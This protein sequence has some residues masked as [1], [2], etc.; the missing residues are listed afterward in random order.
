MRQADI[1]NQWYTKGIT[2]QQT[3]WH[4]QKQFYFLIKRVLTLL[5]FHFTRSKLRK[6]PLFCWKFDRKFWTVKSKAMFTYKRPITIGKSQKTTRTLV[7]VRQRNKR[8]CARL[9]KH[10]ALICGC[11]WKHHESMAP[12]VSQ[13]M[14]KTKTF[15]LD[16]NL[17]CANYVS[18]VATCVICHQL[19]VGQIVD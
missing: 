19:H 5:K 12:C 15:P 1:W 18:Y 3:K 8:R 16:Q 6:Q 10:C 11:H 9:C 17:T 7:Q 13:I 14:T 4:V 2:Y